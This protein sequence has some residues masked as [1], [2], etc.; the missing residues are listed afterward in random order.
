MD[1]KR[2][3]NVDLIE[4]LKKLYKSRKFIFIITF[5]FALIG[6][7]IALLSPI[8]YSSETIFIT[9]NQDSNSSSISG[10]ASLV[11][12]NL[13]ASNFGGEIPSLMYPQVSQSPKFKRLLLNEYIDFD[14]KINL[15]KYLI[16][17]II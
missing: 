16:N 6:V 14:E 10:V 11:G 13:G 9:Q 1:T 5:S 12:I 7:V 4:L 15:K 17:I 8:K 3:D 2:D